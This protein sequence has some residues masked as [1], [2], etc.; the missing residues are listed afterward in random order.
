MASIESKQAGKKCLAGGIC[1]YPR[2]ECPDQKPEI[3]YRDLLQQVIWFIDTLDD[4]A[5]PAYR[6]VQ[7]GLR[8]VMEGR[9]SMPEKR[10]K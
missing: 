9:V 10:F 3:R 5:Q 7:N 6:E 1:L 8:D 2:C 4:G